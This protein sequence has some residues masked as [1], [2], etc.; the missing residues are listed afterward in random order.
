MGNGEWRTGRPSLLVPRATAAD[1]VAGAVRFNSGDFDPRAYI[2]T[3]RSNWSG[4]DAT[5]ADRIVQA[6]VGATSLVAV[7]AMSWLGDIDGDGFVDLAFGLP[8]GAG[9]VYV[10]R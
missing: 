4:V 7:S 6:S 1:L 5:N 8:T 9:T 2:W 10:V 3:G